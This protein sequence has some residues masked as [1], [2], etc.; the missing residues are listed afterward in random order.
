MPGLKTALDETSVSLSDEREYG[1]D[2]YGDALLEKARK[3]WRMGE[4]ESLTNLDLPNLEQH[5]D[6]AK[7]SLVVA[8]AW[9]QQ[10]DS[11][12][13]K[14]YLRIAMDW[15]C[16]K[17]LAAQILTAGMHNTLGRAAAIAGDQVRM[18]Q[19]FHL[20]V[21]GSGN[22]VE[23]ASLG[24]R[25]LELQR[26]GFVQL[27]SL[28]GK[29]TQTK[30]AENIQTPPSVI[31]ESE[32]DGLIS[33]AGISI[34]QNDIEYIKSRLPSQDFVD[35][36]FDINESNETEN[37][38]IIFSTPRC[39]ST[40]LSSLIH[41]NGICVPHEYFQSEQY[42]PVLAQRW[43]CISEWKIDHEAYIKALLKKRTSKYGWAGINLHSH[44]I[45]NFEAFKKFFPDGV[46]FH[47]V[48]LVRKDV[49]GQAIS[50]EIAE[51]TG[52]WTNFFKATADPIYRF[53]SISEKVKSINDGNFYIKSY[54]ANSAIGCLEFSYEDL[55]NDPG[56]VL[57]Q[58]FPDFSAFNKNSPMEKQSNQVNRDWRARFQTDLFSF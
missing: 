5:P 23:R 21:V 44:H 26:L 47:Y 41:S 55:S 34:A 24:R 4:W 37:I 7:L 53:S 27:D 18:E 17:K 20:A 13:A 43:G 42:L 39:G 3:L 56:S 40:Y 36:Q 19:H 49:L 11:A 50:Y 25:H 35:E 22:Q 51:Q 54:I 14:R 45:K 15:N 9:L 12:A 48:H 1:N 57:T 16:D 32:K 29:S 8:S 30:P 58:L 52:Q 28:E 46:Q 6:R 10:G 38:L 33:L 2:S 31:L